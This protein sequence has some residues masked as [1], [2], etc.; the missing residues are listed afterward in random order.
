MRKNE[1]IE[2]VNNVHERF[3]NA[4][5][6]GNQG[7]NW[8]YPIAYRIAHDV[9][10]S[11]FLDVDKLRKVMSDRQNDYYK[12]DHDLFNLWY[13]TLETETETLIDILETE[14]ELVEDVYQA[15]RSGGWLEVQFTC[16]LEY[17]DSDTP[18][19]DVNH[20]VKAAKELERQAGA[21]RQRIEKSHKALNE[22]IDSQD[23]YNDLIEYE[24]MT[25]EEIAEMY[26]DQINILARKLK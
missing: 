11:S 16:E 9:K 21:V 12:N 13:K 7:N 1:K 4:R 6:H 20:Y 17:I 3:E 22:Y 5:N 23:Y 15:G 2:Y 26:Q 19:V 8:W 10:M 24:L 25:D 18:A 14:Y